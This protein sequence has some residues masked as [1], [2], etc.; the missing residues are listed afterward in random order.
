MTDH[1]HLDTVDRRRSGRLRWLLAL[2]PILLFGL[3]IAAVASAG[4]GSR[5]GG[6][7]HSDGGHD[8]ERMKERVAFGISWGLHKVDATPEQEEQIQALALAA[9]DRMMALRE[10][11]GSDRELVKQIF[12]ADELDREAIERLRRKHLE[13]VDV[14]SQELV[15]TL[16]DAMAVLT[17]EQRAEI[18]E[19]FEDHHH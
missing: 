13:L 14:A 16:T 1:S 4:W 19:R 18:V 8:S 7:H 5:V 2:I 17:P 12:L 6:W 11:H 10:A 15:G 3:G 9:V